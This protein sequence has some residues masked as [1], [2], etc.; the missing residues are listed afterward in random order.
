[1]FKV[2]YPEFNPILF[3]QRIDGHGK[4]TIAVI[5]LIKFLFGVDTNLAMIG[6]GHGNADLDKCN[7]FQPCSKGLRWHLDC[8]DKADLLPKGLL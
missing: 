2:F 1:M 7:C 6:S 3:N 8:F 4:K 5:E